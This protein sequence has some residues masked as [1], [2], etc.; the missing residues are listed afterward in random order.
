[1]QSNFL[2]NACASEHKWK[3]VTMANLYVSGSLWYRIW[4]LSP[5][6]KNIMEWLGYLPCVQ[7]GTSFRHG[8]L[9]LYYGIMMCGVLRPSI[10]G[11]EKGTRV[12]V[13]AMEE[14]NWSA[15]LAVFGYDSMES[16]SDKRR[17][18]VMSHIPCPCFL[19]S[20]LQMGRGM[21][22]SPV[23]LPHPSSPS[24]SRELNHSWVFHPSLY[25]SAWPLDLWRI[26]W[27]FWW[28]AVKSTSRPLPI[29]SKMEKE[30]DR[31]REQDG[32]SAGLSYFTTTTFPFLSARWI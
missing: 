5:S 1:M 26:L 19:P 25:F 10:C 20:G 28:R 27:C 31:G 29:H 16:G 24:L 18:G 13:C 17:L 2:C 14:G 23:G 6:L 15:L 9:K 3:C 32:E 7:K 11:S 30:R 4:K 21:P 8:F 12:C 22:C